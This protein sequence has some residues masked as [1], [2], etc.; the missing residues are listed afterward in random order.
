MTGKRF[1]GS[2]N[3]DIRDSVPDC[4]EASIEEARTR[5]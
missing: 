1:D 3:V 4:A 2:I 5:G